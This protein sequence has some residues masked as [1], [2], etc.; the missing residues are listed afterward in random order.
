MGQVRGSDYL[1]FVPEETKDGGICKISKSFVVIETKWF[2]R[3]L[4]RGGW[5][6]S[7]P[8]NLYLLEVE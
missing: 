8:R 2:P 3:A 1:G 7:E 6:G 4:T 5:M